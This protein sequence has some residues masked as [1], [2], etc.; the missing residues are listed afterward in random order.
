MK[1]NNQKTVWISVRMHE[2]DETI[3]VFDS[4]D[5][6]YGLYDFTEQHVIPEV[7]YNKLMTEDYYAYRYGNTIRAHKL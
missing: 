2:D 1:A 7:T 6:I 3:E 4:Y 5:E